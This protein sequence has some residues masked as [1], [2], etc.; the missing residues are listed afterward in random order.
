MSDDYNC[1]GVVVMVVARLLDGA[2][3]FDYWAAFVV[4]VR[5]PIEHAAAATSV[6]YFVSHRPVVPNKQ[7][8]YAALDDKSCI[9]LFCLNFESL[10]WSE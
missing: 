1:S 10:V 3:V 6:Q 5:F 7:D 8:F 9:H 4:V 2:V